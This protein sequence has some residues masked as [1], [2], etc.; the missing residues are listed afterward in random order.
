[1]GIFSI[2]AGVVP[3]D[4][5]LR[6]IPV[7]PLNGISFPQPIYRK[8]GDASQSEKRQRPAQPVSVGLL[9][10]DGYAVP[11]RIVAIAPYPQLL[12]RYK[13]GK[14][15]GKPTPSFL[16]LSIDGFLASPWISTAYNPQISICPGRPNREKEVFVHAVFQTAAG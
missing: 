16:W 2:K 7:N 10:R 12:C 14:K 6:L 15:E 5:P 9:H 11:A 1:M 3:V 4:T 8:G 13:R